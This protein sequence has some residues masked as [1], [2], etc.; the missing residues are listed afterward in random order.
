MSIRRFRV[1][2]A[3]VAALALLSVG[4]MAAAAFGL[5]PASA[6]RAALL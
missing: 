1:K 5:A 2:T 6:G 4:G 3:A